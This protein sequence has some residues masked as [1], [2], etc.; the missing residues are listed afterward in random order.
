MFVD[1]I[2]CVHVSCTSE[3]IAEI[4]SVCKRGQSA[5][6]YSQMDLWAALMCASSVSS[7][8]SAS[9]ASSSNSRLTWITWL[10][11][12]NMS[13]LCGIQRAMWM[14]CSRGIRTLLCDLLEILLI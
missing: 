11:S 13:R 5:H 9:A 14:H 8:S 2:E 4:V 6:I 1:V 10:R 12:Q 7:P 3:S